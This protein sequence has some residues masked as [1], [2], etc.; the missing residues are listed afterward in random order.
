MAKIFRAI[1][2]FFFRKRK[3]KNKRNFAVR[4]TISQSNQNIEPIVVNTSTRVE[5]EKPNHSNKV[6][7]ERMDTKTISLSDPKQKSCDQ[8][9]PPSGNSVPHI[10]E[11]VGMTAVGN[12]DICTTVG[13]IGEQFESPELIEH[14]AE[15]LSTSDDY[16][17][18]NT[19]STESDQSIGSSIFGLPP[20]SDWTPVSPQDFDCSKDIPTEGKN[21]CEE[22]AKDL[23]SSYF[24]K[25]DLSPE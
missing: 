19:E 14:F 24:A 15:E 7:I 4:E 22:L 17:S 3:Q 1:Y 6:Q 13:L 21:T 8:I 9:V 5:L 11:H 10:W 20:D 25:P 12:Y 16:W 2:S 23:T 18:V